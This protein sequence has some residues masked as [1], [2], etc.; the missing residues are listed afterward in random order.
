[1]RQLVT[2]GGL[3]CTAALVV[4]AEPA[5]IPPDVLAFSK[6]VSD[7]S[8]LD[9]MYRGVADYCE[10]YVPPL[11]IKQSNTDWSQSNGRYV[12]S[13]DMAIQRFVSARV[14]PERRAEAI[15]QMKANAKAWFRAAHEK[16]GVL[17]QV[18]RADNKASAC[19]YTLGTMVSESFSLKKMFPA[20]DEYWSRNLKP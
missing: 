11:I 14:E 3:L 8:R 9:G 16:S 12:G 18:E 10:Q 5:E 2:L 15:E 7:V 17:D 20:D 19:S 6:Y 13:L 4:A 1:L